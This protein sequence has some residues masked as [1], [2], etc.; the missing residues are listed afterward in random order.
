MFITKISQTSPFSFIPQD[1]INTILF[2]AVACSLFGV[3]GLECEACTA[4][5]WHWPILLNICKAQLLHLWHKSIL[6]ITYTWYCLKIKFL[7]KPCISPKLN[8]I[9]IVFSK[10]FHFSYILFPH[11]IT[12][13][14]T[15]A[16]PARHLKK[17]THFK[18]YHVNNWIF[19]PLRI[20]VI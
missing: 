16:P 15:F 10:L 3:N 19:F 14:L 17:K 11:L 9:I 12:F 2:M 7:Y 1:Y 13:M 18:M 5:E 6:A 8:F 4:V 20:L